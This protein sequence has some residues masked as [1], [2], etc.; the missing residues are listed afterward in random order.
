MPGLTLASR[1]HRDFP[2]TLGV[3]GIRFASGGVPG[4]GGGQVPGQPEIQ[5]QLHQEHRS[6]HHGN[7]IQTPIESFHIRGDDAMNGQLA[8]LHK[9]V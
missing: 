2:L 4:D 9:W 3:F 5:Q 7:R 6:N 8:H 1:N